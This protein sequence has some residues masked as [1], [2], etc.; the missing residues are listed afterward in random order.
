M[1]YYQLDDDIENNLQDND[2]NSENIN[3][4]KICYICFENKEKLKLQCNHTICK[5][6]LISWIKSK[7]NNKCPWCK[8]NITK[9]YL[10]NNLKLNSSEIKPTLGIFTNGNYNRDNDMNSEC[11][12]L[13]FLC[14]LIGI[15]FIIISTMQQQ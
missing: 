8:Q 15:I 13:K 14:L 9:D 7:Y 3:R 1:S 6:C 10:T 5:E 12:A 4:N 11:N 2:C